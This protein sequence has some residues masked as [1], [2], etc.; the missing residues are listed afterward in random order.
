[1]I[2]AISVLS[3]LGYQ[4]TSLIAGLS[5]GGVALAFAAQKTVENLF[6]S[7]S[8]GIDQP[9][10][11]GD[12]IKV[13]SL[14]GTV[15]SIGLRSTRIR[16]G[17][18]TVVTYPN[19]KLADARVERVSARDRIHLE[20][21]LALS[22]DAT[23]AGVRAALAGIEGL[24]RGEPK[25]APGFSVTLNRIGESSLD[26]GVDAYLTTID[27]G[28]FARRR[29]ELLLGF[30]GELERAGVRLA[31]PTRTLHLE[32]DKAVAGDQPAAGGRRD[33]GPR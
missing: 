4:V 21:T 26:V 1:V 17:D 25:V 2:A 5:V 32:G 31:F 24:L 11:V 7:V 27:D 10:R 19:G 14:S 28:E 8:I 23:A 30:L 33:E 9:F 18:R 15:E 13:D 29:Q 6:G 16:T 20:C 3:E 22:R 12:F